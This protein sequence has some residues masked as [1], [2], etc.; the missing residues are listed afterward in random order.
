[1]SLRSPIRTVLG[2]GAAKDGGAHWWTQRVTS[3][4]LVFLGLWFV[5]ALLSLSDL[6][7]PVVIAWLSQPVNAVLASLFVGTGVYHSLLGVQ[8]VVEDYVVGHGKK[9]AT[10]LLLNFVHV[11]LAALGIFSILKIAFGASA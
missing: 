4:A 7:Y 8:V 3:V 10:M 9:V 1:M 5:W 6:S 2:H 11:A